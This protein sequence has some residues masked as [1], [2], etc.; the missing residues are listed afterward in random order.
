[1]RLYHSSKYRPVRYVQADSYRKIGVAIRIWTGIPVWLKIT[2]VA[3]DSRYV[4]AWIRYMQRYSS[5]TD[6]PW[7]VRMKLEQRTFSKSKN[8]R[9][10][11]TKLGQSRKPPEICDVWCSV[12]QVDSLGCCALFCCWAS[13]PICNLQ[14]SLFS[15]YSVTIGERDACAERKRRCPESPV[16]L[17]CLYIFSDPKPLPRERDE[18]VYLAREKLVVCVD[19]VCVPGVMCM[20]V[21]GVCVGYV[22]YSNIS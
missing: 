4:S 8:N 11:H 9:R 19:V 7:P 14:A 15:L 17:V 21:L 22:Q 12:L 20:C 16:G 1:M 5:D 13:T 2:A 18:W 6:L 10:L 3:S